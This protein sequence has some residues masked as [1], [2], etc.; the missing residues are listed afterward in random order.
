MKHLYKLF[1]IFS[2]LI[3]NLTFAQVVDDIKIKGLQRVEPGVI[4]DSVPFDI[5][6]DI[7]DIDPSGRLGLP[8]TREPK[9][10]L[11]CSWCFGPWAPVPSP[12]FPWSLVARSLV[13]GPL[14]LAV[15]SGPRP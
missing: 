11:A 1:F 12:I 3:S 5:G 8:K 10:H 4:F 7:S 13:Y 2:F 9:N 6:D 14:P 15:V